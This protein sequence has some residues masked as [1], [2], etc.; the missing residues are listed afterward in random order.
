MR[1]APCAANCME[2]TGS[3][4]RKLSSLAGSNAVSRTV[5]RGVRYL[6]GV[7]VAAVRTQVAL[8]SP[9]V[10]A[11]LIARPTIKGG[12]DLIV[13]RFC[14]SGLRLDAGIG[15][16]HK[17]RWK[18]RS[19]VGALFGLD[20][21]T[22]LELGL[23]MDDGWSIT[24]GKG[25]KQLIVEGPDE[26]DNYEDAFAASFERAQA[27][28]D[29]LAA[30]RGLGFNI[31]EVDSDHV[32]WWTKDGGIWMRDVTV[33]DLHFVLTVGGTVTGADGVPVSAIRAPVVPWHESMRYFRLSQTTQD[34]FDAYRNLYL[35][36]ESLLST[37]VPPISS[38]S[39]RAEPEGKWLRRAL[40][41]IH[42]S[43]IDFSTYLPRSSSD[44]VSDIIDDLYVDT[45]TKLFHAKPDRN[46]LLPHA[47]DGREAVL[48]SFQRLGRFYCDMLQNQ[49][50]IR[51]PTS[52]IS[53]DAFKLVGAVDR[54]IKL[55]DDQTQAD[56]KDKTINPS[57]GA[58]LSIPT[59]QVPDEVLP[60]IVSWLGEIPAVEV[61]KYMKTINRVGLFD[62]ENL[63]V[64]SEHSPGLELTG[65]SVYQIQIS[66][67]RV[68]QD[69]VKFRFNT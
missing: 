50:G 30:T 40:E 13:R 23:S 36:V 5:R 18:L 3:P 52:G 61:L 28:L 68:N 20:R 41:V 21:A 55:S 51:R 4:D 2:L 33:A 12:G 39:D 7:L 65:A 59:H 49:F 8:R 27:A 62:G 31:E 64:I 10:V 63:M 34:L 53:D 47:A 11:C 57:G 29:L 44:P 37:I 54:V 25:S 42:P 19:P 9:A 26:L 24:V 69:Y 35:A 58:S 43:M 15:E 38:G 56:V 46:N 14:G 17:R 16:Q 32:V 60:G 48:A 66:I 6:A 22:K 67:R 45:R 1:T